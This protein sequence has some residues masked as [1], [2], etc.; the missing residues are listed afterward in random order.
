MKLGEFLES[1]RIAKGQTLRELSRES[2]ISAITLSQFE[3]NKYPF[4]DADILLCAKI[5][6]CN[7][8]D[9]KKLDASMVPEMDLTDKELV[10]KLPI[11]L[12]KKLTEEQLDKIIE[13]IR[14]A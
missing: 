12:N 11:F 5:Y 6:N 4:E 3:R 7:Y 2:K 13:I 14:K 10:K 1:K 9:L 8:E